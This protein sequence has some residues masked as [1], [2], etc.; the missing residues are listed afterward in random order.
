MREACTELKRVAPGR[1]L[2][3]GRTDRLVVVPRETFA[4]ELFERVEVRC[5]L[6]SAMHVPTPTH[7]KV[8][9][10][11]GISAIVGCD[12]VDVGA[13]L[14]HIAP[15]PYLRAILRL[16]RRGHSDV[17]EDDSC[18]DEGQ[19]DCQ[20]ARNEFSRPTVFGGDAGSQSPV[21]Q[22]QSQQSTHPIQMC[23]RYK[24]N[25]LRRGSS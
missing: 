9:A 10:S 16:E 25:V 12:R 2:V 11:E 18:A 19:D 7:L 20:A 6:S 8:D 17:G 13:H 5:Q 4:S 22:R 23:R 3:N 21:T 14:Y 15:E 24:Q 1:C